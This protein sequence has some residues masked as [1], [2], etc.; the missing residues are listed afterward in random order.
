MFIK[1]F[2]NKSQYFAY[3]YFN[4]FVFYFLVPPERPIIYEATRREKA[5]TVEAYNE[6][7]D[8]VLVCEVNG[9]KKKNCFINS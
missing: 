9:G 3:T 5:K 8:V 6:G 1:L 2:D 4:M 7:S